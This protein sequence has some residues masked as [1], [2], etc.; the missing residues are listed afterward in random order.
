MRTHE[1][2][3]AVYDQGPEAVMAL[4][5][6]LYALMDQQQTQIAELEKLLEAERIKRNDSEKRERA[7]TFQS[8]AWLQDALGQA[9]VEGILADVLRPWL[10]GAGESTRELCAAM[11]PGIWEAWQNFRKAAG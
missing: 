9:D 11:A 1:E 6:R 8:A 10:D 2:I 5:E 7:A 3:R 4:V